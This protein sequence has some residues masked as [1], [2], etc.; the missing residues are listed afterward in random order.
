VISEEP[1]R[2][3]RAQ[4][5]KANERAR[6]RK[7]RKWRRNKE[8]EGAGRRG[9]GYI[10]DIHR[11]LSFCSTNSTQNNSFLNTHNAGE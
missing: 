5:E 1:V 4:K 6:L 3:E 8:G 2:R 10:K 11:R 9:G 7:I